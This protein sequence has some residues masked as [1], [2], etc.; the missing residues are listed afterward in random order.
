MKG[1]SEAQAQLIRELRAEIDLAH[2]RNQSID[3]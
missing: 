1:V 3:I 2:R